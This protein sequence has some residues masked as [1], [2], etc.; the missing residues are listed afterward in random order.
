VN[1]ATIFP[2]VADDKRLLAIATAARGEG[3]AHIGRLIE[4]WRNGANRFSR[5]GEMLLGV[6]IKG[7]VVAVGGLN[8]DPYASDPPIGRM[9]HLYVMLNARGIG[10]GRRLVAELLRHARGRFAVVRVRAAKGDAPLFYD[11]ISWQRIEEPEASH[12][13]RF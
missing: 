2:I 8:R 7:E 3:F 6:E 1:R 5:A 10:V 11:A 9:R 4:N 13:I 12:A